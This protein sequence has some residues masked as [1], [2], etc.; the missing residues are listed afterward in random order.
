MIPESSVSIH[1]RGK[2]LQLLNSTG[3]R[4]V[5]FHFSRLEKTQS[6]VR[7]VLHLLHSLLINSCSV[8]ANLVPPAVCINY[9]PVWIRE[10]LLDSGRLSGAGILL[11]NDDHDNPLFLL[12]WDLVSEGM[13]P[14]FTLLKVN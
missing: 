9:A 4:L 10:D 14:A 8:D 1:S 12:P 7:R 11:I 13:R 2:N 3:L 6:G 5:N